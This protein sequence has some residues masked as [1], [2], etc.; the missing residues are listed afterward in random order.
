MLSGGSK[1]AMLTFAVTSV[2]S[3]VNH[4]SLERVDKHTDAA[5]LLT[6]LDTLFSTLFTANL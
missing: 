6:E 3:V 4:R 1:V 5:L 2:L